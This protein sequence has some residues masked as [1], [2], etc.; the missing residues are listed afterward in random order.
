MLGSVLSS[1]AAVAAGPP[2]Q[3]LVVTPEGRT[4]A[5]QTVFLPL[6]KSQ[7]FHTRRALSKI[8]IGNPEIADAAVVSSQSFY[9][10]GKKAGSTSVLIYSGATLLAVID[11]IVGMD[12]DAVKKS[13]YDAFPDDK[14]GVQSVHDTLSLN[15]TV[16]S[17]AKAA[18]AMEIAKQFVDKEKTVI[19]NLHVSGS[20]QVMLQVKVAEI[21]RNVS[22]A[23][24]FRPF[25]NVSHPGSASGFSLS[26]LDPVN[27]S[28][29]ALAAGTIVSGNF[30][31]T[32]MVDALEQKGAAQVLAEPNL[33]AMSGDTASFLAG[34][35]FPIPVVQN[36]AGVGSIAA[37]TI[38]FKQF[39]ISLAFTPTV[40]DTDLINLVVAPEVSQLDPTS[41]V[42][43]NGFVIPGISTRRAK[44][45][46]E[47]RDGQ[48]FA[49]AGLLSSTF[50]D[51][52]RGIPALM[53]VPVIGALFR[54]TH[55][56]R[57]ETELVIIVTPHLVKP[58][59]PNTLVAPTDTF[60]PPSDAQLFL[61]ANPEN[62]DSGLQRTPQGG[63]LTGKYGHIIR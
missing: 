46:V 56:Q 7:V 49:I 63:G 39:G 35:E 34:G 59:P 2:R 21:Q 23:L 6:N 40:V 48:S 62:P 54:G 47:L 55:F 1:N 50:T 51:T 42:T 14:I 12:V 44:T 41:G 29:F 30:A 8:A 36:S 27:I 13:L 60:V 31:F 11:A 10:F 45:T 43:L 24:D 22:K 20:Q 37:V 19:N 32:E 4:Q 52:I 61:L 38:E 16:N 53:N 15:G 26:T 25:L 18:R 9:L 57:N 28:N 58:A 5:A 3:E 33:I 17:P